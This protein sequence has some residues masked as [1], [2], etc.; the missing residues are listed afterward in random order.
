MSLTADLTRKRALVTGASSSGLGAHFAHL[1][2]RSGAEVIVAARRL[3]PLQALVSEIQTDGGKARAVQLDVSDLNSV[4][5]AVSS[6]GTLDILVNNAGVTNTKRLL[7]QTEEDFDHIIGTNLKGAWNTGV[8]VARAMQAQGTGGSIINIASI[9][10]LR[11]ATAVTPYA[12]SKA[13]VVQLT[14]QM[15]LELA[16]HNIRVNALAPGYFKTDINRDFFESESGRTLVKRLPMRRL[17]Q[18][19][20]LDGAFLLLASDASNYMTG[21]IITVD[22]G[23]MVN[24]L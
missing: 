8:E 16:R 12:V 5:A 2:A 6:C 14:K 9:A 17:G 22:G 15:A 13:G 21:S 19:K 20:E 10:G 24:S 7:E 23:H 3:D 11:Q 18:F 1:L 4:R